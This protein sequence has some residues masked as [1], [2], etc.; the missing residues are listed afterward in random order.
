MVGRAV[1]PF[2][3]LMAAAGALSCASYPIVGARDGS[4]G[5]SLL[6]PAAQKATR[7]RIRTSESGTYIGRL[8]EDRDSVLDRWPDRVNDPIRVWIEPLPLRDSTSTAFEPAVIEAF[9]EWANLDIP[10]QFRFVAQPKDA[11]VRVRWVDSLPNKTGSTT[12][13][14]SRDGWLQSGEVMLATH[15]N[16]GRAL[17]ARGV[18]AI[19]LHEIGHL[20]GLS[21]SFDPH[22]VMAS[23]VRVSSL[24]PVDCA[25]IRL[26]YAF[27][28]GHVR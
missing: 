6:A 23:L 5:P 24:S 20:L 8:L 17:D 12:W 19:A 13:R 15:L 18:R 2:V 26:L 7:E 3:A 22:D 27:Q 1:I 28:A 9:A 10:V 21:H 4:L 14:A 11:E 25:T 16:G